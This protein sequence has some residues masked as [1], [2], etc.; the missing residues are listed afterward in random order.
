[1]AKNIRDMVRMYGQEY[2]AVCGLAKYFP[3]M[4]SESSVFFVNG[5]TGND[6]AGGFGQTPDLPLLTITKALSLC[7]SG[8][9]DYIFILD[10]YQ[11]TGETFPINIA[12]SHIHIIGIT[13]PA[14]PW[15]WVVPATDVATFT[16][17]SYGA[18]G[19]IAGLELGAGESHGCIE[20]ITAGLWGWHIHDCRF[21]NT[22]GAGALH[23]IFINTNRELLHSLIENCNFGSLI[24][25]DGIN[26]ATG[27]GPNSVRG[28]IIRNNIFRVAGIGINVV[29]TTA[30]FD[31]GGILNN[32][33]VLSSDANGKGIT[34]GTGAVG[35][36]DGNV[37]MMTDGAAPTS[38]PFIGGTTMIWGI[39]YKG[40]TALLA[41]PA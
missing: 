7:T 24:T 18:Y 38:N 34:F 26:V 33:F 12:K 25:G 1:M 21:G 30:D 27:A 36:V 2:L 32:K 19:E 15:P 37:G 41:A 5:T 10:Y 39:N 23:G 35:I 4:N 16:F 40:G 29:K 17:D 22:N 14:V 8:K 20:P 3:T 6:S 11:A 13:N 28:T 9:N 31:E